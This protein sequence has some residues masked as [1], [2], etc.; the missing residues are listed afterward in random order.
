MDLLTQGLLGSAMAL[1][2]SRP[3]ESRQAGLIGLL[4][5]IAADVDFFISSSTDPLLNLEYH[6]HFTHSIFLFHW[7]RY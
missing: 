7:P 2:A 6:R 4:A 3:L 5:G 1:S